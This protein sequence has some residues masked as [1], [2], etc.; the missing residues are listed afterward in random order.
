MVS[1]K[2]IYNLHILTDLFLDNIPLSDEKYPWLVP[3]SLFPQFVY[4]FALTSNADPTIMSF[5]APFKL[6]NEVGP[7]G[8]QTAASST[9]T[10]TVSTASKAPTPSVS[11]ALIYSNGGLTTAQKAAVGVSV[12]LGVLLVGCAVLFLL[13]RRIQARWRMRK[14]SSHYISDGEAKEDPIFEKNG[15]SHRVEVDGSSDTEQ[16]IY[17]LADTAKFELSPDASSPAEMSAFNVSQKKPLFTKGEMTESPGN[18]LDS[19]R[20]SF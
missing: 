8:T 15:V 1:G 12:S 16:P 2:V 17:E 20:F 6:S 5:S 9:S 18:T 7:S 13:L 19:R 11:N 10:A 4:G 14:S 3:S